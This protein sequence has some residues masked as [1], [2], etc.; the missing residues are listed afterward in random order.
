MDNIDL[1]DNIVVVLCRPRK[2]VNIAGAIRAM[3]NMG[4]RQLRL[5]QPA[6]YNEYEIEGIAHRS[7]DVLAATTLHP[8]LDAALADAIYV[9]GTSARPREAGAPAITPRASA[10]DLLARSADGPVALVFGPED[11]GLSNAELDRCHTLL[12]IPTDPA[13]PSL[14][15]AQAVL[16]VAYELRQAQALAQQAPRRHPAR[17]ANAAQLE[18]LFDAL[19]RALWGIEFFKGHQATGM[20][21]TLRSLVHRAEPSARETALLKAMAIETLNFLWRKGIEP[22]TPPSAAREQT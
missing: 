16:L 21:R 20:L 9:A 5:V 18:E 17:P 1:L 12:T 4:L 7:A 14:N 6:E 3:K 11:N 15:L 2:L 8:T 22:Q 19:E 13:Y 10:P